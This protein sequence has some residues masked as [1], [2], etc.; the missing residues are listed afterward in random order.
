[1]IPF[2]QTNE[3][4]P[5]TQCPNMKVHKGAV[6]IV[7]VPILDWFTLQLYLQRMHFGQKV[8]KQS[9]SECKI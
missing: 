3:T 6:S 8:R 7:F 9:N 1:M 2:T 4:M 5:N